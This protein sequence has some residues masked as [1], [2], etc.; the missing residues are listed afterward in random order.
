MTDMGFAIFALVSFL[1]PI[2]ILS[3][4]DRPSSVARGWCRFQTRGFSTHPAGLFC[5]LDARFSEASGDRSS[6]DDRSGRGVGA[7]RPLRGR[8][9]S[10]LTNSKPAPDPPSVTSLPT[11]KNQQHASFGTPKDLTS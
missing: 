4:L 8:P 6:L 10:L 9:S 5:I 1:I 3:W 7:S 2:P 11:S